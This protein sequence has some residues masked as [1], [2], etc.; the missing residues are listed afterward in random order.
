MHTTTMK[1]KDG[2]TYSG[3]LRQ[4]KPEK[5]Y[6]VL[7]EQGFQFSEVESMVTEGDRLPGGKIGD[8]DELQRARDYLAQGRKLKWFDAPVMDWE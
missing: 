7:C 3:W 5:N 8:L 6:F 1:T 2:R 4:F